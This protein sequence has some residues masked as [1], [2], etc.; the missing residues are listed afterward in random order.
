M[1]NPDHSTKNRDSE[2]SKPL[3]TCKTLTTALKTE[4]LSRELT[5]LQHEKSWSKGMNSPPLSQQG[6]AKLNTPTVNLTNFEPAEE[7]HID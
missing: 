2:Q 7:I 6:I 1:E 5:R 3:H 4:I